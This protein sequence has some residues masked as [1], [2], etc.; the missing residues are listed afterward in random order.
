MERRNRSLVGTDNLANLKIDG[1]RFSRRCMSF[2]G[3]WSSINHLDN[4]LDVV[5]ENGEF[6]LSAQ[7]KQVS[8]T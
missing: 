8:W 5:T 7:E 3:N 2:S 1:G 4:H 6:C